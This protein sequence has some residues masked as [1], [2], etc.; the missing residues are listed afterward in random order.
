[1]KLTIALSLNIFENLTY[2][3]TGNPKDIYIGARVIV[4][5]GKLVRIGWVT[6]L[7][8]E[9]TGRT[10][11]VIGLIQS[12]WKASEITLDFIKKVSKLYLISE[13]TLLDYCLL[14]GQKSVKDI[15]LSAE[16]K[17]V[18]LSKFT[19]TQLLE[20]SKLS[21][22]I[23]QYKKEPIIES[24]E[25]T[26]DNIDDTDNKKY[27][28]NYLNG[29]HRFEKYEEII[30]DTL[31]LDKAVLI[32]VPDK[33]SIEYFKKHIPNID[34]YNSTQKKSVK[35]LIWQ[36]Y[37][38]SH[39]GV[40]VGGLSALFLQ[41]NNLGC[42]IYERGNTIYTNRGILNSEKDFKIIAKLKAKASNCLVHIG[43]PSIDLADY[44]DNENTIINKP[45]PINNIN[46]MRVKKKGKDIFSDIVQ[47][48]KNY[49]LENKKILILVNRKKS[50]NIL[51]CEKCKKAVKCKHCGKY[52][53]PKNK[54]I[55]KCPNCNHSID[56]KCTVCNKPLI[57]L[58][59]ISVDSILNVLKENVGQNGILNISA[60]DVKDMDL[61]ISNIENSN[62][63]ISTP[64]II[65]P[66]FRDLFD[67]II[68]FKPES[69]FDMDSHKTAENIFATLSEI[70]N[71]VKPQ[72]N[73]DVFSVYHFLYV[74]KLINEEEEFLNRELKY[75]EWF[76]LPPFYSIYEL[77]LKAKSLRELGKDM[78]TMYLKYKEKL[79]IR[80]I[81]IISRVKTRG[82]FK[83]N[84]RLH[85]SSDKLIETKLLKSRNISAKLIYPS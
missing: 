36:K 61:L 9:Y 20:M 73:I 72:G 7:N 2:K 45:D 69:T 59:D 47:L 57:V 44:K 1:M 43:T 32:I 56:I 71:I 8:S 52:I 10:R 18:S 84:L 29:K 63:I 38:N 40:I 75:R 28:I 48:T 76:Y 78:R 17:L 67:A 60:D 19:L 65:G 49:H 46:V 64:F 14:P 11:K 33:L 66:Y 51:Y 27:E 34:I 41:I 4:P 50:K 12:S 82:T 31:R 23:F 22:I 5:V 83:G 74:F 6:S 15:Y 80:E 39:S 16:D 13:G 30:Q 25:I 85:T 53:Q 42:V 35:D 77:T 3:Y 37:S 58:T 54:K 21:P 62:I 26:R 79:N 24:Q 68:Y 70:K 55:D 81:S